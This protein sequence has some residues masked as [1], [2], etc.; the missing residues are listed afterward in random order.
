VTAPELVL[1]GYRLPLGGRTLVM[2]ILNATP[3]S[4]Y[5]RGRHFGGEASLRRARELVAAGADIVDVGGQT[6]QRG[7]ELP[8]AEELARVVGVVEAVAA[9][10]VPVSVDTYRAPVADAAL[11][12]GAVMV[13]D[14]TGF[15]DPELPAV[16]AAHAAAL[17]CAHYRGRPRSNPSRSYDV[18]VDEVERALLRCRDVARAAG[19][20]EHA[21]LLDPCFGFGKTTASDLA[22]L[23]A[24]PRLRRH[25]TPLLA[26]VSHKEFTADATGLPED[27][28]RGTLAA[29]VLA[30]AG[31]AAVLRLHD[32]REVVPVLRLADAWRAASDGAAG[33]VGA[34]RRARRPPDAAPPAPPER[35]A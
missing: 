9:L 21:L 1:G 27:D 16:A 24:L 20:D 3:D 14:Y 31:G 6:G 28:L 5:D 4:F 7:G 32:V 2:G 34:Q 12:A 13:N 10:G 25:G 33:E 15:A 17:V 35:R 19:V 18:G 8:V 26:A 22:L 29:A 11:A 23:A 30:A